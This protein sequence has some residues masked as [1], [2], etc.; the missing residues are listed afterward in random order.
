MSTIESINKLM[1]ATTL[2]VSTIPRELLFNGTRIPDPDEKLSVEEVREL[3]TPSYP[4][5][6][7]ASLKGPEDTGTALRYTFQR[8]IGTKG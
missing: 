2:K 4:D 7:T 6:A 8:A 5:L 1:T 3:L